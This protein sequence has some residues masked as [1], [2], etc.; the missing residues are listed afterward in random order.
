[1]TNYGLRYLAGSKKKGK[2]LEENFAKR[3]AFCGK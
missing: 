2:R 3:V 1:M